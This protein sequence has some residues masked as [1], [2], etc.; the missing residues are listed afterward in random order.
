MSGEPDAPDAGPELI[1]EIGS[2]RLLAPLGSGGMSSVFR[3]E[4]IQ[5]GHVVALKIL[6]KT[7]AKKSS[8]LQ[9]FL[10]E[11][12]SAEALE[13]PHI[14][15]IYDRGFDKGRHYLALEY[16]DGSDLHDY[17]Q[18][19]G[20][21]PAD[22]VIPII[23]QVALALRYAAGKGL[24]HRDIKP[25]NLLLAKDGTAKIIDLGLA[26]QTDDEDERVTRDG[27]T[28]GTV[29]YMSPE[30][31]RDSR[32][33]GVRGDI[34]SLGCTIFYVL[35]GAPPYAGGDIADKLRRHA[36]TPPPDAR[37]FR[38]DV[39]EALSRLVRRMMAKRPER[40]FQD[41]DELIA[42]L[43][44]LG[45]PTDAPQPAEPLA[46]LIDDE[47]EGEIGLV[48]ID[49][50]PPRPTLPGPS[51][52][53]RPTSQP[54]SA[55]IDDD[56]DDDDPP[57]RRIP[58]R[59][60]SSAPLPEPINLS[61]LAALSAEDVPAERRRPAS[62][63]IRR[64]QPPPP[65]PDDLVLAPP[66]GFD[67]AEPS[68]DS[69]AA[70]RPSHPAA[71]ESRGPWSWLAG[72]I[73]GS[74]LLAL[75]LFLIRNHQAQP[76]SDGSDVGPSADAGTPTGEG[77]LGPIPAVAAAGKGTVP[78]PKPWVEPVEEERKITPEPALADEWLAKFSP[79]SRRPAGGS[80][81]VVR[82]SG[83]VEGSDESAFASSLRAALDD[84]GAVVELADNGPFFETDLR[85]PGKNRVIRARN[86]F[87]PIIV[88]E[89]PTIEFLQE[90]AAT[91]PLQGT[92]LT[93]EGIDLVVRV[94]SLGKAQTSLFQLQGGSLTLRD[95]TLTVIGAQG[96][97]YH[98]L[99]IDEP[100][101]GPRDSSIRL[102]SSFVRA[103]SA[104]IFRMVGAGA[105][106]HVERSVLVADGGPIGLAS[107]GTTPGAAD[108]RS[109]EFLRSITVS[110]GPLLDLSV[111]AKGE[112]APFTVRLLGST[113]GRIEGGTAAT[114]FLI[115]SDEAPLVVEGAQTGFL[116]WS[117]WLTAGAQKVIRLADASQAQSAWPNFEP[118]LV[119][120]APWKPAR[121]IEQLQPGDL[122]EWLPAALP[123]LERVAR[124]TPR[125][126][127]RTLVA[128]PRPNVPE[129]LP[130][131]GAA[132]HS[133]TTSGKPIAGLVELAF[134]AM[135]SPWNGDLG[136][137]LRESVPDGTKLVR[138][139]V[140][141]T[142][143]REL[144]P[145]RLDPGTSLEIVVDPPPSGQG[146][147]PLTWIPRARSSAD[148]VI[149]VQGADLI[150]SGVRL[151]RSGSSG[152]N[153]LVRVEGGHLV[154]DRCRLD[155]RE[156]GGGRPLLLFRSAV[157]RDLPDRPIARLPRSDRPICRLV[158]SLLISHGDAIAAEL[159]RG[160]LDL[161]NCVIVAEGSAF[162]LRP[163]PVRRDRFE[164]DLILDHCTMVVDRAVVGPARW[165]GARP[166]PDRPWLIWSRNNAFLDIFQR[167]DARAPRTGS[168]VR[169]GESEALAVGA[170]AWQSTGDA[171][172]MT[173][174]VVA[175]GGVPP[176]PKGD[177]LPRRRRFWG[178]AHVQ[179]AQART[180]ADK[181]PAVRL[182]AARLRPGE[183]NPNEWNVVAPTGVGADLSRLGITTGPAAAP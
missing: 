39:P 106:I 21:L 114:P 15:A 77:G 168:M 101:K 73:L 94:A 10:R 41:Y 182:G 167:G 49:G 179:D 44:E 142:G 81:R 140:S 57:P 78:P 93:L 144:T 115:R 131:R 173:H 170:F 91:I 137:F 103:S 74:A 156:G 97:P 13:H 96:H 133:L 63:A 40:R 9:R 16:V 45:T 5:S 120:N 146:I 47:S 53:T 109:I 152:T 68:S 32:A 90:Q 69:T 102:E 76:P 171:F 59:P 108:P 62:S 183:L 56:D 161:T 99:A 14:V 48:P 139:H 67:L 143:K 180:K 25:A 54:P 20:P 169:A 138:V 84:L 164:A 26:L 119:E 11:A 177:F 33:T 52:G 128:Y 64:R 92:Q 175:T 157:T 153:L 89:P 23:R 58:T 12:K 31:A 71:T 123:T 163:E 118:K 3:A 7:L 155:G 50:E 60:K 29:D 141:G 87:R 34:Y 36:T 176:A 112:S 98:V 178:P 145:I 55:L 150:L 154:L 8:M 151:A 100:E 95:C 51:S 1:R 172:E 27:T 113:V 17:V 121:P 83:P 88:V 86:G 159:A 65:D 124:P 43:D 125:L 110:T 126:L 165:P 46:A 116:G 117:G 122:A 18:E 148:A 66:D 70:A 160:A 181:Q 22:Q 85:V 147:V 35:T 4:H 28:V 38:A 72:G 82:R 105:S 134:D 42:A 127:E 111:A 162:T 6:P 2:Y 79:T 136:K 158:D 37:Q 135:K 80:V 129:L 19:H 104:A 61:A 174:D 24:I 75:A 149:D 130:Q 166:G 132:F 107:A 30:Q